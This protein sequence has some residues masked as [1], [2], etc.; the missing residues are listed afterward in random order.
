[1]RAVNFIR[2]SLSLIK[3]RRNGRDFSWTDILCHVADIF[4][5]VAGYRTEDPLNDM[6]RTYD[7]NGIGKIFFDIGNVGIIHARNGIICL[8]ILYN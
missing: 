1:M 3:N 7:R 4:S 6:K 8:E 2:T 5:E